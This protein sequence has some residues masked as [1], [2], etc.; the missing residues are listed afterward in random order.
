MGDPGTKAQGAWGVQSSGH[1]AYSRSE[2]RT[3][4]RD[5]QKAPRVCLDN[6]EDEISIPYWTWTGEVL[7]SRLQ[8]GVWEGG[9]HVKEGRTG[10]KDGEKLSFVIVSEFLHPAIPEVQFSQ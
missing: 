8:L 9:P 10:K 2:E 4:A 3:Q 7:R 5:N 1:K 6:S